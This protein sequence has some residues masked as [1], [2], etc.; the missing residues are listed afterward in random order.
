M[1]A[2]DAAMRIWSI[3]LQLPYTSKYTKV[4][5]VETVIIF[6]IDIMVDTAI[7]NVVVMVVRTNRTTRAPG[8]NKTDR[9]TRTR[10]RRHRQVRDERQDRQI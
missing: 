2:I 10:D 4:T 5:M 6:T 3:N 1:T 7:I 8:T 9:I